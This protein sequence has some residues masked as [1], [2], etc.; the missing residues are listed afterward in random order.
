[1][2]R[3]TVEEYEE[4]KAALAT[5]AMSVRFKDKEVRYRSQEQMRRLL[6]DM[7]RDLGLD[8]GNGSGRIRATT[9]RFDNGL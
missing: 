8:D 5:G 9:P 7:E 3:F 2:A 1:M 4:L 6:K